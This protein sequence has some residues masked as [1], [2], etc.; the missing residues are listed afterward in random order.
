MA[1]ANWII[2]RIIQVK[3]LIEWYYNTMNLAVPE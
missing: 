1:A 3:L 2:K